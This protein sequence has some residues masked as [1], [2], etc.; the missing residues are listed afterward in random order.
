MLWARRA[1]PAPNTAP[2]QAKASGLY[3][4]CTMAKHEAEAQG[5]DDALM[6]DWRSQLAEGTGAQTSSWSSTANCT[7]R[8]R[9]ASSTASCGRP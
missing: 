1:R 3:M 5:C 9:I 6:L 7:P 8:P 4:I 2:T